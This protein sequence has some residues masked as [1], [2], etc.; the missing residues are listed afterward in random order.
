LQISADTTLISSSWE[1]FKTIFTN[2][3][4]AA[5]STI[6]YEPITNTPMPNTQFGRYVITGLGDNA[7][8]TSGL[9][10]IIHMNYE[11]SGRR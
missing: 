8:S 4:P 10:K 5:D 3:S 6:D 9:Y 7:K 2:Y 1:T 11:S